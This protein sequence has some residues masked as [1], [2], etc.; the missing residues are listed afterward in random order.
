[1]GYTGTCGQNEYH[2]FLAVLPLTRASILAILISNRV[3]VWTLVLNLVHFF[4]RRIYF[5]LFLVLSRV[6]VFGPERGWEAGRTPS[7]NM[8][9]SY[10]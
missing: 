9:G 4:L 5:F 8:S 1:M 3:W 7:P 10:P 2:G 6:R